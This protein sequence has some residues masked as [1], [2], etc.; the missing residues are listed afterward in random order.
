MPWPVKSPQKLR[1]DAIIE[2][3]GERR[4]RSLS[5]GRHPK[6][7]LHYLITENK[8]FFGQYCNLILLLKNFQWHFFLKDQVSARMWRSLYTLNFQFILYVFIFFFFH[9][10]SITKWILN[11]VEDH[12]G[13]TIIFWNI[14]IFF[15]SQWSNKLLEIPN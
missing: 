14:Y 15:R 11:I 12:N 10:Y 7:T 1:H 6:W 3:G 2:V 13:P 5:P 4:K 8:D 9:L